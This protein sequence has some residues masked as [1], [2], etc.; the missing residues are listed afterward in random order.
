M[1]YR[2]HLTLININ[3]L[4]KFAKP[5]FRLTFTRKALQK[6]LACIKIVHQRIQI[7]SKSV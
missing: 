4:S 3:L 5:K 6:L 1:C 2:C 7:T